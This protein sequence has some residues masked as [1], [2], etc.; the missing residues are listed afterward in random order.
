[1]IIELFSAFMLTLLPKSDKVL[2]QLDSPECVLQILSNMCSSSYQSNHFPGLKHVCTGG[3]CSY[4][5]QIVKA[6]LEL[7][8]P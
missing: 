1:M 4:P 7:S 8:P 3:Y 5:R 2:A 6:M